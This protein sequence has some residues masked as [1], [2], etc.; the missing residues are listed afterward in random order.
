[1]K[2]LALLALALL[3]APSAFAYNGIW[4]MCQ[5][6]AQLEDA[7]PEPIFVNLYEFRSVK[8]RKTQVTLIYKSYVLTGDFDSSE[9]KRGE[10]LLNRNQNLPE[11]NGTAHVLLDSNE[12]EL[13]GV[14]T[15]R[16]QYELDTRLSCQLISK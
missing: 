2:S 11:F 14:L 3:I 5:G 15:L 16:S 4:K 7:A 1:M 12:V 9:E 13:K 6:Q 10:V 8:G